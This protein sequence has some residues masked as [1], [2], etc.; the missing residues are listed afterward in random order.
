VERVAPACGLT[1]V[2]TC[3]R[4]HYLQM[5]CEKLAK[6]YRLRDTKA[7]VDDLVSRHAGFAKFIGPFFAPVLKNGYRGKDELELPGGEYLLAGGGRAEP[8]GP[9]LRPLPR[10]G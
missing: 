7:A 3:H 2:P 5:A 6:A 9:Y 4:L 10:F 8:V 1:G